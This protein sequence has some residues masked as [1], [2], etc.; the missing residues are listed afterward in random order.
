M[1][2][3]ASN[4]SECF[5]LEGYS[6]GAA[7]TVDAL[8][9]LTGS[10]FDAVKGVFLIGDPYHTAGLACNI[11]NKGGNETF[12][13]NGLSVGKGIIPSNWISKTLDVCAKV[14]GYTADA[15]VVHMQY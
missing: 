10:A 1:T 13:T 12:E 9:N 7:A 11:D 14:G 5:F 2:T 15:A 3:L 8:K 6:Q 4:P